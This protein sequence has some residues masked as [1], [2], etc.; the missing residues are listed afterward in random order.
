MIEFLPC[1]T[2]EVLPGDQPVTS[3]PAPTT[4]ATP[5]PTKAP[6]ATSGGLTTCSSN[7]ARYAMMSAVSTECAY[8]G[9]GD[10]QVPL[11]IA[12][13]DDVILNE[14]AYYRCPSFGRRTM[15]GDR[16]P[17]LMFTVA[18]PNSPCVQNNH[19]EMPLTPPISP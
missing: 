14:V 9:L 6:A 13:T 5:A 17:E 19:V 11:P 7:A 18:N 2:A 4:T 12:D 1:S 15:R 8:I 10:W 16:I 3:A